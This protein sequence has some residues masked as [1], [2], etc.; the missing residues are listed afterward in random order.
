MGHPVSYGTSKK[1]DFQWGHNNLVVE[2]AVG[3]ESASW[4]KQ[5]FADICGY[6]SSN[7]FP[8]HQRK[9]SHL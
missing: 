8:E 3:R 4:W 6:I 9:L 1:P 7:R 2:T 5:G